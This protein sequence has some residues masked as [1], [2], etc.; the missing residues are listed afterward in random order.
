MGLLERLRA[1]E[2]LVCDG[3]TGTELIARGLKAGECP[4]SWCLSRSDTI[5]VGRRLNTRRY[6]YLTSSR[7]EPV[8]LEAAVERLRSTSAR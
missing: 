7:P 1:D 2:V 6:A 3:A 4:E 8:L 5:E